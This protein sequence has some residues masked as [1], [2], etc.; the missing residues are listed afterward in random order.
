MRNF[1]VVCVVESDGSN[2]GGHEEKDSKKGRYPEMKEN[3]MR[4][5]QGERSRGP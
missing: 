3:I 5:N 1:Q 4:I 2:H